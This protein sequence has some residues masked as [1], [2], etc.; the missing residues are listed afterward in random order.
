MIKLSYG[1]QRQ[2]CFNNFYEYYFTLGFLADSRN[3]ELRWENNEDQGAWGSEGRIHCLVPETKFPQFFK[4]TAGRG[5]V[6][7]RINCNEYVATLIREHNFKQKS[8]HQDIEAIMKT[9][10]LEYRQSFQDGYGSKLNMNPV[11]EKNTVK[12]QTSNRTVNKEVFHSSRTASNPV[13][14]ISQSSSLIEISV[15]DKVI[16]TTF[17]E[18]VIITINGKIL[19]V[20]FPIHGEKKFSNPSSFTDGFLKKIK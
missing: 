19:C 5:N 1:A 17:G 4:F 10:P 20:S 13:H 2:V 11:Y 3:A 16:H 14:T 6:Y 9:V 18:G 12:Y 15:G 8:K 7:A